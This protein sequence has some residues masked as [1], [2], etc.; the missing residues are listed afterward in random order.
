MAARRTVALRPRGGEIPD[1][2]AWQAGIARRSFPYPVLP[3]AD[4]EAV[5]RFRA[6]K[7]IIEDPMARPAHG[8]KL[9]VVRGGE[10]PL[11][12]LDA[13]YRSQARYVAHLALRVLGREP[14][15]D[16]VVQDV[17]VAAAASLHRLR[18]PGALHAWLGT[19]TVRIARRRL[20]ARRLLSLFGLD[21]QPDYGELASRDAGPEERLQVKRLYA[22]LDALPA[23]E[24]IAWALRHVQG[25]QLDEVARLCGCSLA[26]AKRRIS[27][28][29][30]ALEARLAR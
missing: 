12:P 22:C 4:S 20:R 13:A 5:S 26:T 9:Q 25:E 15:V 30:L 3:R 14:E 6:A 2:G 11:T 27:A 8:M 17:F 1:S 16:D 18:E 10:A 23:R 7:H 28:A 19:V 21:P 29:E 24:R